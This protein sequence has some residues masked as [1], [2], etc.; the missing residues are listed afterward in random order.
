MTSIITLLCAL[1]ITST[2]YNDNAIYLGDKS[3][4]FV[5]N[6]VLKGGVEATKELPEEFYGVW[7][8]TS[9][10]IDTNKPGLFNVTGSDVWRLEK[11]NGVITLSNPTTG[12]RAS[13]RVDE[14]RGQTAKFTRDSVDGPLREYESPT[15]TV[16]GD[17]FV[18]EDYL[19]FEVYRANILVQNYYVKYRIEG[20]RLS[21]PKNPNLFVR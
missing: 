3:N 2:N 5:E 10:L 17:T 19:V 11:T 21:K 6:G 13:I 7:S 14:V 20:R 9:T 16:N 4:V 1:L 15:I 18:G 8:V 12:A